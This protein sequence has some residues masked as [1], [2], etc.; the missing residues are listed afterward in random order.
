MNR[1]FKKSVRFS[2]SLQNAI[3][4]MIIIRSIPWC[5]SI[6][7]WKH[8]VDLFHESLACKNHLGPAPFSDES[9]NHLLFHRRTASVGTNKKTAFG[10]LVHLC[11]NLDCFDI[12]AVDKGAEEDELRRSTNTPLADTIVTVKKIENDPIVFKL[13]EDVMKSIAAQLGFDI[14][15][16]DTD[17]L[18]NFLVVEY[19]KACVKSDR[20]GT[21]GCDY[22]RKLNVKITAAPF[23]I[24]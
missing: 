10:H 21:L 8:P 20:E 17:K 1:S 7:V 15:S 13:K 9:W 6:I 19:Q 5:V 14:M 22:L 3:I 12:C 23:P 24:H 16:I 11:A 4:A 18:E 2:A